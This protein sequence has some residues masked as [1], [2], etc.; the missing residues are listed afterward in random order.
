MTTLTYS[1]DPELR[2]R[3]ITRSTVDELIRQVSEDFAPNEVTLSTR[4]PIPRGRRT[5]NNPCVHAQ[6]GTLN[7]LL[8]DPDIT[9]LVPSGTGVVLSNLTIEATSPSRKIVV[10]MDED[11]VTARVEGTDRYWT[12]GR[13]DDLRHTLE[14]DH[15]SWA[16]WRSP[17]RRG[18]LV[19]GLA[20]DATVAAAGWLTIGTGVLN[21][22]VAAVISAVL[23]V[24]IP[25]L[26]LLIGHNVT[27]CDV[28]V[29]ASD[30]AWFWRSWTTEN[31]IAFG[32]LILAALALATQFIPGAG[33]DQGLYQ[34]SRAP[35]TAIGRELL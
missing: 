24:A 33:S 5:D 15:P 11:Q 20:L 34:P 7:E 32:A 1:G 10:T 35:A 12:N 16:L 9:R 17:R 21:S 13:C 25:A 18:F 4:Y 28:H 26:S 29:G 31:K 27:R 22:P 14:G 6:K 2:P 23:F 30:P 19:L 3:R 8:N